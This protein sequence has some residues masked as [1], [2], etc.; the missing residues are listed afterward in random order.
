MREAKQSGA[1]VVDVDGSYLYRKR[2][3]MIAEGKPVAPLGIPDVPLTG[4]EVVDK[5]NYVELAKRFLVLLQVC[6]VCRGCQ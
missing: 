6:N 5:S 4:W 2:Q 1:K 3:S